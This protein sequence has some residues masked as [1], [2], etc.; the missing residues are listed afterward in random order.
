MRLWNIAR[1]KLKL[2]RNV[3]W[4]FS[5]LLIKVPVNP[6]WDN[7][8]IAPFLNRPPHFFNINLFNICL[9]LSYFNFF[10][11]KKKL[12]IMYPHALYYHIDYFKS[13][14]NVIFTTWWRFNYENLEKSWLSCSNFMIFLYKNSFIQPKNLQ[15]SSILC[16]EPP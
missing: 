15:R 12:L 8:E 16:L 13:E 4:G 5:N 3:P 6:P 10:D 2:S 11:A 9:F 7:R 1:E 14:Y